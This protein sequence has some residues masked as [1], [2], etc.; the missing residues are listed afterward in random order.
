[1]AGAA[2]SISQWTKG[3]LYAPASI[4]VSFARAPAAGDLLVV[5]FWNNGQ[6]SGASN[7]YTPPAGWSA[8]DQ[9]T[10]AAYATYQLFTHTVSAGEANSYAFI[11]FSAQREHAWIGA[12]VT[13][14]MGVDRAGN[15][16]INNGTSFTT[17]ALTPYGPSELAIAFNLP[18]KPNSGSVTWTN[19]APP[20]APGASMTS[21]WAGEALYQP[22]SST[23]AVTQSATSSTS[24]AGFSGIVLLS[25]SPT[26]IPTATPYIKSW[27]SGVHG[28]TDTSPFHVHVSADFSVPP[29]PGDF[30]VVAIWNNGQNNGASNPYTPPDSSWTLADSD[31]SHAWVTYQLW[32]HVAVAG[33]SYPYI[34]TPVSL[35]RQ[36][37]YMVAD[38]I[39]ASPVVDGAAHARIN[40]ASTTYAS[41]T[42]TPTKPN[43]MAIIFNMP[44]ATS[45]LGW[46]NDP[47]WTAGIP[48][49]LAW[50]AEALMQQFPAISGVQETS[51]LQSAVNGW[52]GIVLVSPSG[53]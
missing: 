29:A 38:I 31:T 27:H 45:T 8:A 15:T 12:D 11:P 28:S 42:L 16:F 51:I 48:L 24:V 41:P 47:A 50:N 14:A 18:L 13:N 43:D 49:S 9:N 22:L 46:T 17:P 25:N 3:A 35:V 10:A 6:S 30:I 19:P 36:H 2:P 26:P 4:T 1:M 32:T 34:F 44:Y 39:N 53:S 37:C 21:P 20:W 23:S 33:E 52:S 7:T 5:A 40:P